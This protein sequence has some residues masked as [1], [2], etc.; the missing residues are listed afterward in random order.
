MGFVASQF[1]G[2][3]HTIAAFCLLA[4]LL[5]AASGVASREIRS[6]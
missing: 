6:L 3:P 1:L 4:L 2:T 5:A